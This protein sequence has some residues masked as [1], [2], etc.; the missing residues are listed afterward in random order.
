V[1]VASGAEIEVEGVVV[2][3]RP[4]TFGSTKTSLIG[5]DIY[6]RAFELAFTGT[7]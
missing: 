5:C 4:L 1:D 7:D 2:R 3:G 6:L